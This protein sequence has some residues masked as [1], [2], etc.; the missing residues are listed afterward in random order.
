MS[1]EDF[2]TM[3]I[4]SLANA[5]RYYS[6]HPVF[7]RAFSLLQDR[8]WAAQ[9]PGTYEIDKKDLYAMIMSMQGRSKRNAK[10]EIHRQYIDIQYTVSG[11]DIMGWKALQK[12]AH[13]I[14]AYNA[15]K[16]YRLYSDKPSTWFSVPSGHFVIFFPEDAHSPLCGVSQINKIVIKVRIC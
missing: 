9:K 11:E 16:D 3:I 2:Y 7:S 10:L 14:E 5:S 1:H 13:P 8:K 6:L 4:D 15:E 12:C